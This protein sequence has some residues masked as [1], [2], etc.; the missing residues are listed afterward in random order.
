MCVYCV[1]VFAVKGGGKRGWRGRQAGFSSRLG[2][3]EIIKVN[4]IY[5]NHDN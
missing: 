3:E 2:S 4:I 5:M 1:C